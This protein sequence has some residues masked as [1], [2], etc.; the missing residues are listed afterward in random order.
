V[1]DLV[2]VFSASAAQKALAVLVDYDLCV[3]RLLSRGWNLAD[4]SASCTL[5]DE[6]QRH[7]A[8]LPDMRV[9]WVSVLI[10]RFEFA[11]RLW[12]ARHHAAGSEEVRQCG[13]HHLAQVR[14][15]A[16]RCA[17][18]CILDKDAPCRD[19]TAP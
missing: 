9:A 19:V 11:Q 18:G 4:Y 6:L 15:F 8:D 3:D 12:N 5:F 14:E 17:S 7:A 16:R 1:Q 10:S 13:V 2:H